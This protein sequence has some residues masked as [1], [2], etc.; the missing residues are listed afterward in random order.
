MAFPTW[1]CAGLA[2]GL[3]LDEE[4]EDEEHS[5]GSCSRDAGKKRK[6]DLDLF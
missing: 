5:M 4:E 6:K 3:C 1:L 2:L